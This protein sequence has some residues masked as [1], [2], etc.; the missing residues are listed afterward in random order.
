MPSPPSPPSPPSRT[1]SA[2][3]RQPPPAQAIPSHPSAL[4]RT[5]VL[6]FFAGDDWT[7]EQLSSAEDVLVGYNAVCCSFFIM[8]A[9]SRCRCRWAVRRQE[10]VL[11]PHALLG[12]PRDGLRYMTHSDTSLMNASGPSVR[13]PGRPRAKL[14]SDKQAARTSVHSEN[15][16]RKPNSPTQ[17]TNARNPPCKPCAG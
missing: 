14:S 15:N 8:P 10:V 4:S 17:G 7:P 5:A 3:P 2:H 12:S 9:H 6:V 16:R 13:P 11:R 1:I